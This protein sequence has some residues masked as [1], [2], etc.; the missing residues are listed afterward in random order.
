MEACV[1]LCKMIIEDEKD[2]TLSFILTLFVVVLNLEQT[3]I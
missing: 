1:I 2:V 3:Q